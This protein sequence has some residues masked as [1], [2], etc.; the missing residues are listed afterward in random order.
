MAISETNM[1]VKVD[2][3]VNVMVQYHQGPTVSQTAQRPRRFKKSGT[4]H[5]SILY[6]EWVVS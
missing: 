1:L 4:I 5:A 3:S 6:L 2:S